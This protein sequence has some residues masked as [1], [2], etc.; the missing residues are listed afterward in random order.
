MAEKPINPS[1]LK[2]F[3][4]A[5]KS[6]LKTV[7]F[8]GNYT[9]LLNKPNIPT[10]PQS[11]KN[12]FALTVKQNGANAN[13]YD[14]S[15]AK[16]VD[17]TPSGIGAL[18]I[19]GGTLTGDLRLQGD[20]GESYGRRIRFGDD[21][22]VYLLEN[23]DDYLIIHAENGIN[24]TTNTSGSGKDVT[25]NGQ[26]IP[27]TARKTAT[28]VVGTTKSGH[29]VVDCDYLC[30]GTADQDEIIKAILSLPTNGGKV[31]LLEGTYNF[32]NILKIN[33]SNVT[34]EGMGRGNTV[35]RTT[36]TATILVQ[37]QQKNCS[38][39]N[40]SVIAEPASGRGAV[41]IH[42]D[43]GSDFT[44]ISDVEINKFSWGINS[45]S[46]HNII[47]RV[48]A[49][50][51]CN[52]GIFIAGNYNT[53]SN[54]HCVD[55]NEAGIDLQGSYN[56][57]CGNYVVRS[58]NSYSTSQHSIRAKNTST[59]C[60]VTDNYIPGKNYTNSGGSTNT[61]VDNRYQ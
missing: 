21:D 18:P 1:L 53:V 3:L 59:N 35:I 14:G 4:Q 26:K 49:C 6:K 13:T 51:D 11:I 7:A 46:N 57:V 23:P 15:A 33:K 40:L 32:D 39:K 43:T 20:N 28:K 61:F 50:N 60:Y 38:I 37:F 55:C 24:L 27:L 48:Y 16:T 45:G 56:Q 19:T 52:L 42:C 25:I 30:D 9:D 58:S 31:I 41:G 5:V 47:N 29:T 34:I 8:T 2:V 12:P 54:C 44:T 17:I 22:Y 10:V 36:S